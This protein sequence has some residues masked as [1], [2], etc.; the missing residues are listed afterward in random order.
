[1]LGTWNA[2]VI[3]D[4]YLNCIRQTERRNGH[5]VSCCFRDVDARIRTG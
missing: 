5:Q 4:V 2:S 3:G 1:M